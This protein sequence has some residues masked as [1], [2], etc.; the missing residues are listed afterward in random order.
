MVVAV[1]VVAVSVVAA[2][3]PPVLG[4]LLPVTPAP[5]PARVRLLRVLAVRPAPGP[6]AGHGQVTRHG[7]RRRA[8][9]PPPD[10]GVVGVPGRVR[11]PGNGIIPKPLQG[12]APMGAPLPALPAVIPVYREVPRAPGVIP[13]DPQS[14]DDVLLARAVYV[15]PS[16]LE[17]LNG[18]HV[19]AR[20]AYLR[21]VT[22][23]SIVLPG[24]CVLWAGDA[25]LPGR[26]NQHSGLS[27]SVCP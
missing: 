6:V 2:R 8:A 15:H 23:A 25:A 19:V 27:L 1:P 3:R 21:R 11:D 17:I 22:L 13:R 9:L 5:G 16:P 20:A 10:A 18:P 4:R 14:V 7:L 24:R 12:Q 26:G